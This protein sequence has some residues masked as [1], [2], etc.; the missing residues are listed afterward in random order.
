MSTRRWWEVA[1]RTELGHSRHRCMRARHRVRLKGETY[2]PAKG[3][4][5]RGL[6]QSRF[7]ERQPLKRPAELFCDSKSEDTVS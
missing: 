1:V 3:L 2:Q 6:R 7:V 4:C 5:R